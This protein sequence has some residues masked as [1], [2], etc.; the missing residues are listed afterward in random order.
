MIASLTPTS[1]QNKSPNGTRVRSTGVYAFGMLE[2]RHLTKR[3]S[4]IA[5]VQ[6]V[7]F[8]ASRTDSRLSR[9][10]RIWK[11]HYC[12]D[13]LRTHGTV[14]RRPLLSWRECAQEPVMVLQALPIWDPRSHTFTIT[15]VITAFEALAATDPIR[16]PRIV[17]V[18]AVVFW[19]KRRKGSIE[20][21]ELRFDDLAEPPV[22][23]LGS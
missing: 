10:Q 23:I 21:P 20:T 1:S 14:R 15:S 16:Q 9:T 18:L 13:A 12:E 2:V 8:S 4:E 19:R 6:N 11:E 7:S 22:A 3:Y 17:F 5:A